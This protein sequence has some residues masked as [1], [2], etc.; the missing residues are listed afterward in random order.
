MGRSGTFLTHRHGN[1]RGAVLLLL[2]ACCQSVVCRLCVITGVCASVPGQ[3]ARLQS[4]SQTL[5]P[6]RATQLLCRVQTQMETRKK[7]KTVVKKKRGEVGGGRKEMSSQTGK[8]ATLIT[9][10][11]EPGS[12]F[13]VSASAASFHS[14]SR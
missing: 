11:L 13:A 5:K 12:C 6:R 9:A 14:G 8:K 2:R 7:I 3:P 10:D 4:H 1:M